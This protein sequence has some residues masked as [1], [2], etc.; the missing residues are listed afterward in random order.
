MS[1]RRPGVRTSP[2]P[3]TAP[4]GTAWPF[5]PA[6]GISKKHPVGSEPLQ[7]IAEACR[8]LQ[9]VCS[10]HWAKEALAKMCCVWSWKLHGRT[11]LKDTAAQEGTH[12]QGPCGTTSG[13][14]SKR[15][16]AVKSSPCLETAPQDPTALV[17]QQLQALYIAHSRQQAS[18]LS[19]VQS[20]GQHAGTP[21]PPTGLFFLYFQI[22]W[23]ASWNVQGHQHGR[24]RPNYVWS[25]GPAELHVERRLERRQDDVQVQGL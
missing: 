13:T 18:T 25:W 1:E 10:N 19:T 2:Q 7:C 23:A 16:P 8:G 17:G 6:K 21:G 11:G 14:M 4:Q 15:R 9:L 24:K 22:C 5:F 20:A 3:R 12:Q